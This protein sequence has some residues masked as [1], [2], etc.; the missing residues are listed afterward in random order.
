[1]QTAG[2]V[3]GLESGLDVVDLG[4]AKLA[5][6]IHC[7][8]LFKPGNIFHTTRAMVPNGLSVEN[9]R[10]LMGDKHL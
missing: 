5:G 3:V 6:D 10:Q 9:M 2:D 4:R 1:M 8:P 7:Q